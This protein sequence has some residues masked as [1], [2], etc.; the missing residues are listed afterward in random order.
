M[1]DITV[2][3]AYLYQPALGR[4][5]IYFISENS[6]W[7]V[8]KGGGTAKRLVF[9]NGIVSKPTVSPDGKYIAYSFNEEG[10]SEVYIMPSEGGTAKRLTYHNMPSI[11]VGWSSDS[12]KLYF[13][14]TMKSKFFRTPEL[15]SIPVDGGE[16]QAL[17]IGEGMWIN[18]HKD[19]KQALIGK[20]STELSYWK[21]YK[22]G[23]AGR[24]WCGDIES[25]E[26]NELTK[27][28]AGEIMPQFDGDRIIYLSDKDGIA[29]IYSMDKDGGNVSQHTHYRDYYVRNLNVRDGQAVFQYAG[30]IYMIDLKTNDTK[31]IDIDLASPL[32]PEKAYFTAG[33]RYIMDFDVSNDGKQS[34]FDVRGKQVAFPNWNGAPKIIGEKQGV[35]YR[36]STYINI[37]NEDDNTKAFVCISD[38]NG[39]EQIELHYDSYLKEKTILA[40]INEGRVRYLIPS[41][42][43]KKI[44]LTTTRGKIY[45]LGVDDKNLSEIDYSNPCG[46]FVR[47]SPSWSPDNR[48]IAYA[49]VPKDEN[50]GSIFI[51]DTETKEII[52]VTGDE[53]NDYKPAFDPD[54]KYLYFS[55]SRYIN[56]SI[57]H[58]DL[59]FANVESE[60]PYLVVLS[61][62]TPVPFYV[63]HDPESPKDKDKSKK[64]NGKKD[65]DDTNSEENK[66]EVKIDK[67]GIMERIF[68]FPVEPHSYTRVLPLKDKVIL[69]SFN[70]KGFRDDTPSKM[71][72]IINLEIYDFIENKKEPYINGVDNFKLSN[73]GKWIIYKSKG[74]YN[75]RKA[76][77]KVNE[78]DNSR[79]NGGVIDTG[80]I[81]IKVDL[82][83]E[84][85]QIFNEIWRMDFEFFFNEEMSGVDWIAVKNKYEPL[86]DRANTREELSD[87]LWEVQGELGTSH[88]YIGGGDL[89]RNKG[90]RIGLLGADIE[91]DNNKK[92]YKVK[93][94]YKG[95]TFYKNEFSPLIMPGVNV[96][97]GH[98]IHGVNGEACTN[99]EHIYKYLVNTANTEVVL[100]V[101]ETG[102]EEDAREVTVKTISNETPL[103]Y[104]DWVKSNIEYVDDK[105]NGDAGYF[106]IPDMGA[107]G[108]I[109]F[110]RYFYQFL[111]KKGLILDLRCNGGGFVSQNLLQ[112]LY[113]KL[114]GFVKTRW[115]DT[116]ETLPS[117]TFRGSIVVIID[118]NAGSDGDIFPQSFKNFKLGTVVGTRTWGGVVGISGSELNQTVDRGGSTQPQYAIWF[119]EQKYTVENYGVDPD[120]VVD[121]DPRSVHEGQDKQLDTAIDELKK[122]MDKNGYYEPEF[123][124]VTKTALE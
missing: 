98:Y 117:N 99:G 58:R 93:K 6:L 104:R 124:P 116:V 27:G 12:S 86:V 33:D 18:I 73:N 36:L 105:T 74:K 19:G 122:L 76:G 49:K 20:N 22:G 21:R 2:Q 95:D 5:R 119:V 37:N 88:A 107:D 66:I 62:D 65:D 45:I 26:F 48:Y 4:D 25:Y 61:K 115:E 43:G 1:E 39:D 40:N 82:K 90:Y 80:R 96:S 31:K 75:V 60:K 79:I 108:L 23:T 101:S 50:T 16:P 14:S 106:H 28:K 84:W 89:Q 85:K 24:I 7:S 38:E 53:F 78:K 51:Y 81:K 9:G 72:D 17:N 91:Y 111:D 112:R 109:E 32:K 3:K 69:A 103:I 11:P 118:H 92:L 13:R 77:E 55:S 120:I 30:D 29:N 42:D 52:R 97:E 34:L 41:N 114:V 121:N 10:S 67:E 64:K 63:P 47:I 113:K 56:P 8:S 100:T 110:D 54:G 59:M 35:R 123:G 94:I 46:G 57:D 15:Y 71:R 102:N 68:E 70:R 83:K 44:A 87:I